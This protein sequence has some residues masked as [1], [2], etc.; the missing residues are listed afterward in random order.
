MRANDRPMPSASTNGNP[1]RD[2]AATTEIA[3]I[4]AAATG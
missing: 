4:V 3:L 2:A 1:R